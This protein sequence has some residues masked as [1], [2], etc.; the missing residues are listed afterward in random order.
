MAYLKRFV[1]FSMLN[2]E[3]SKSLQRI[4]SAYMSSLG[5]HSGDAILLAVLNEHREG[6][7]AAALSRAC[8]LDRAAISRALP[9]LLSQGVISYSEPQ[10]QGR[11]YRSLLVLTEKGVQ[12]VKKMRAFTIDTVCRTSDD[13]G[14][15]ELATFY[16]VFR[17]LE[18][19]LA[20]HARTLEE[21]NGKKP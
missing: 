10:V 13:I 1:A 8:K 3:S 7:S 6:L 17:K 15:E 14:S 21:K 19:R 16:R 12:T 4:K 11:N 18:R 9:S 5:L 20:E 2:E